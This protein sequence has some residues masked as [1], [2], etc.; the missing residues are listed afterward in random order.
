M[1]S[2]HETRQPYAA[3]IAVCN[4]IEPVMSGDGRYRAVHRYVADSP[5][6]LTVGEVGTC[7]DH[8]SNEPAPKGQE[9]G[10]GPR[11]SEPPRT[12]RSSVCTMRAGRILLVANF[13]ELR[14]SEVRLRRIHLPRTPV[15]SPMLL[16]RP[17]SRSTR[18]APQSRPTRPCSHRLLV[19]TASSGN[20]ASG[21]TVRR[22]MDWDVS[23]WG[24]RAWPTGCPS[25]SS[26]FVGRCGR[27]PLDGGEPMSRASGRAWLLSVLQAPGRPV[28]WIVTPLGW[29]AI[30]Q[31][32][33]L[34]PGRC[35]EQ[36]PALADDHGADEQ[37]ELI[38]E[39][40]VEQDRSGCRCRAPPAH[41]PAWPSAPRRRLRPH[42]RGRSCPPTSGR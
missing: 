9:A 16:P 25:P 40:V 42:R 18:L 27:P 35:R 2:T 12:P 19:R 37:V 15:N 28:D 33:A 24:S 23:S 7:T 17:V 38:D 22:T 21:F 30:R 31:V 4:G 26:C 29:P 1:K 34:C 10:R 14:K 39:V 3:S 41:L 8:R 11:L 36:P 13:G 5:T 32:R 6:S 20:G